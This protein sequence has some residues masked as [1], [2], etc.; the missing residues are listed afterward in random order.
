MTTLKRTLFAAAVLLMA[1]SCGQ[2]AQKQQPAETVETEEQSEEPQQ[3]TVPAIDDEQFAVLLKEIYYKLPASAMHGF[4]KTEKQR[5]ESGDNVY[6]NRM[7]KMEWL[8][9][10]YDRW[11]M[12]AY[13]TEDADNL[14]LIVQYGSGLDGYMTKSDKTFNYNITTGA[15]TEIERPMDPVTADELIDETKE[16]ANEAKAFFIKE[17]P[18]VIYDD[19]DK[20]GFKIRAAVFY[21]DEYSDNFAMASRKW[22]GSRFVKGNKWYFIDGEGWIEK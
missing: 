19:F 9:D 15:L 3:E 6:G 2:N 16:H 13:L 4:L 21:F 5:R 18:G 14:V 8:E 12:A 1:A 10:G 11:D 20:D 7:E 17:K 22:N